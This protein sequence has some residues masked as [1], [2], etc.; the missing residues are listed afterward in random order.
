MRQILLISVLLFG[1]VVYLPISQTPVEVSAV[2]PV[3]ATPTPTPVSP[4][5]KEVEEVA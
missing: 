4:P 2:G 3:V 5:V 1:F